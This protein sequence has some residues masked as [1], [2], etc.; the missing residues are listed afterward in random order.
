MRSLPSE[1]GTLKR[2]QGIL[3]QS[4][5]QNPAWT[6]LYVPYSLYS[7][8]TLQGYLADKKQTAGLSLPVVSPLKRLQETLTNRI[9]SLFFNV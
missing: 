2:V 8:L 3:P 7:G 4:Q 9:W 1:E 6:V 5:G